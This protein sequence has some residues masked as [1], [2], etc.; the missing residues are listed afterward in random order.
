MGVGHHLKRWQKVGAMPASVGLEQHDRFLVGHDIVQTMALFQ[1]GIFSGNAVIGTK[2]V[3]LDFVV[4][5]EHFLRMLDRFAFV[6]G[7]LEQILNMLVH[8]HQA[9]VVELFENTFPLFEN[10]NGGHGGQT[11]FVGAQQLFEAFFV[12]VIKEHFC[13]YR[14][15]M[16]LQWKMRVFNKFTA[17]LCVFIVQNVY[18]ILVARPKQF[19]NSLKVLE[20]MICFFFLFFLLDFYYQDC[21]YFFFSFFITFD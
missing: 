4:A 13:N 9:W 5:F 8:L 12:F 10:Q 11:H 16:I 2:R 15:G 6:L 21:I 17:V 19:S 14:L 20:S 18:G 1:F 3:G 7:A